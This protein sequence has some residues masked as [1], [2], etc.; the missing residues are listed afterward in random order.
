MVTKWSG[1]S[2]TKDTIRRIIDRVVAEMAEWQT[3]PRR[4]GLSSILVIIL[5][6]ALIL[7]VV[8]RAR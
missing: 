2:V 8:R 3:R 5:L 6:V 4:M 1:A 7:F